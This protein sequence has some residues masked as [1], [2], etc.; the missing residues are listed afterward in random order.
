MERY[1]ISIT[2]VGFDTCVVAPAKYSTS[3]GAILDYDTVLR[4]LKRIIFAHPA[5]CVQI[6]GSHD[7][8]PYFV[9]LPRVDLNDV[10]TYTTDVA[11]SVEQVVNAELQRPFSRSTTK[12]LWR[13]TVRTDNVVVFAWHHSIADGG[14]A[15]PFHAAFLTALNSKSEPGDAD[16][17]TII[18]V[19]D[20]LIIA[21][22]IEERTSIAVSP[23]TLFDAI[24]DSFAPLAVK[25][26]SKAWTAKRISKEPHLQIETRI[27]LID[28]DTAR[29]LI[30]L[31][32]ERK[33]TLTA[34]IHT[35]VLLALSHR[36]AGSKADIYGMKKKYKTFAT[37]VPISLRRFTGTSPLDLCDQVTVYHAHPK[38]TRNIPQF[39]PTKDTFP[40]HTAS[41][42]ATSLHANLK[43]ARQVIGTIGIIY[44]LGIANKY[45]L[46][47][48][49]EKRENTLVLSNIGAMPKLNDL[50][51]KQRDDGVLWQVDN[52]GFGQ[53]DNVIA[54]AIKLNMAGSPSGTIS[55][56]Y[57]WG[58]NNIDTELVEGV[59]ADVHDSISAILAE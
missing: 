25:R 29:K 8:K 5:L 47:Q 13:V 58:T 21:P 38:I 1:H 36:L 24:Y 9:R 46:D 33:C 42:Y 43:K 40:W 37:V 6:G 12:P 57:N 11:E 55:A 31:C 35:L 3:S 49:G 45:F 54:S 26:L 41:E 34:F 48:L 18:I 27:R 39:P 4:A 10:L 51:E 17:S 7:K 14:C 52:I 20:K 59:I 50:G 32:R 22:A 28:P 23:G 19:P 16:S 44:K 30:A 15:H 53:N 56:V 2:E